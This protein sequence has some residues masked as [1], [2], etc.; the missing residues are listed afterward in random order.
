MAQLFSLVLES[1]PWDPAT[2]QLGAMFQ[3]ARLPPVPLGGATPSAK[4]AKIGK[5]TTTSV[6]RRFEIW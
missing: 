6:L 3:R 5:E 1:A 4:D 2:D